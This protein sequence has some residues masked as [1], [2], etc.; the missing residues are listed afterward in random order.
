M[1][2]FRFVVIVET[3]RDEGKFVSNDSLR[4]EILDA[5]EGADPGSIN[6]DESSYSTV[7]WEVEDA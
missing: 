4:E 6:V 5:L 3:E 7:M 1:A 2:V